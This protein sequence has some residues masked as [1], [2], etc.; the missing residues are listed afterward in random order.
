MGEWVSEKTSSPITVQFVARLNRDGWIIS[1]LSNKFFICR[2]N[3]WDEE[4]KDGEFVCFI[5]ELSV[6]KVF[7]R[8]YNLGLDSFFCPHLQVHVLYVDIAC[9]EGFMWVKSTR[10]YFQQKS[11]SAES[12]TFGV[13]GGGC[14]TQSR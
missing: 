8:G 3:I 11:A 2:R 9:S 13:V 14:T 6:I 7:C 10:F 12:D 4:G 5:L 1:K